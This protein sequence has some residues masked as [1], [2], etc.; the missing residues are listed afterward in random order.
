MTRGRCGRNALY[1]ATSFGPDPCLNDKVRLPACRKAHCCLRDSHC[2]RLQSTQRRAHMPCAVA[3]SVNEEK[4]HMRV[5]R[6]TKRNQT[7]TCSS[8]LACLLD[9][10]Q[11]ASGHVKFRLRGTRWRGTIKAPQTAVTGSAVTSVSGTLN[12]PPANK[13]TESR[14]RLQHPWE[15]EMRARF[16]IEKPCAPRD[17][18]L[19]RELYSEKRFFQSIEKSAISLN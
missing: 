7:K 14:A 15:K 19:V 18:N 5:W 8:A 9:I 2:C 13:D 17:S 10:F 12:F 16:K 11:Q 1:K 4:R 3:C 6:N